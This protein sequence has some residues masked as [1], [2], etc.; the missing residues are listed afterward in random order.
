MQHLHITLLSIEHTP[1]VLK[2]HDLK[3]PPVPPA[4]PETS[5]DLSEFSGVQPSPS[6][7][8]IA[9]HGLASYNPK[10]VIF[11]NNL[12]IKGTEGTG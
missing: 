11:P 4:D 5:E 7:V 6:G 9:H 10:D 8:S 2:G 12:N 1:P 3:V